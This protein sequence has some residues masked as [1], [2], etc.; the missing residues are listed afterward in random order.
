[1]PRFD[2]TGPL[3]QGPMTGGGRGYCVVCLDPYA[4]KPWIG[5]TP[6]LY[7]GGGRG[8]RNWYYATGLPGW[9]RAQYGYPP[10]P[11]AWGNVPPAAPQEEVDLLK[12]QAEFLKQ[13]LEQIEK[14]M[15]GLQK[16]TSTENQ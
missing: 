16:S 1:M 3:G 8:R 14:R 15:E 4:S 2:G 11:P 9:A 12:E 7:G 5:W 6:R 10:F 13:Q